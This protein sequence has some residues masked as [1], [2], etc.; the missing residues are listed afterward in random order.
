MEA[1]SLAVAGIGRPDP[2]ATGLYPELALRLWGAQEPLAPFP[3]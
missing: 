3:A 2:W 1:G